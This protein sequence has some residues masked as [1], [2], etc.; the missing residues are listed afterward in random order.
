M[1][2][3]EAKEKELLMRNQLKSIIDK[4]NDED[5]RVADQI[6]PKATSNTT[7]SK[8]QGCECNE[9]GSLK[10]SEP[11]DC[12]PSL[13]NGVFE[14][15]AGRGVIDP[16][17]EHCI[18]SLNADFAKPKADECHINDS[19][20]SVPTIVVSFHDSGDQED[21]KDQ[22][23]GFK[24][25]N[26]S[27]SISSSKKVC[28]RSVNHE[29]NSEFKKIENRS[30]CNVV[31]QDSGIIIR[32]EDISLGLLSTTTSVI[33]GPVTRVKETTSLKELVD[34]PV[35]RIEQTIP[36]TSVKNL[37]NRPPVTRVE[38]T[39]S[40]KDP[41]DRPVTRV[42]NG[43]GIGTKKNLKMSEDK[44]LSGH[45]K[46]ILSEANTKAVDGQKNID[47]GDKAVNK[48]II[49]AIIQSV[50][51]YCQI[52]GLIVNINNNN[53]QIACTRC[54]TNTGNHNDKNAI[55][56]DKM[57]GVTKTISD[58][59]EDNIPG[60]LT[61]S[62]TTD[63][64]DESVVRV[65]QTMP[66]TSATDK[67]IIKDNSANQ[68]KSRRSPSCVTDLVDK[69]VAKV[70]QAIADS[71]HDIGEFKDSKRRRVRRSSL[72]RNTSPEV[73]FRR[74]NSR[75][76]FG[77]RFNSEWITPKDERGKKKEKK[78]CSVLSRTVAFIYILQ[79]FGR[80]AN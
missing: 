49:E 57:G 74:S 71:I 69:S 10:V 67:S 50:N 40:L 15:K 78:W 18:P 14:P 41:V 51:K 9:D 65:K 53:N 13:N 25:K 35:V 22:Q 58:S 30:D 46:H 12:I 24:S 63:L 72:T 8:I 68:Y 43:D 31:I 2:E 60:E 77:R 11:E 21:L 39:S 55:P 45:Q 59:N 37:V 42:D 3:K 54:I 66:V 33:D 29:S 36:V 17:P 34:R 48:N 79:I 62:K 56:E 38:Q 1:L 6:L 20:V 80:L 32:D 47:N 70:E 23:I 64:I 19:L 73:L 61:S 76:L 5:E 27:S 4:M 44:S 7:T 28:D 52:K 75:G 16:K 26:D